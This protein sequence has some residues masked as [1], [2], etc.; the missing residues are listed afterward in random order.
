MTDAA[1][2]LDL[3]A[4]QSLLERCQGNDETS[5]GNVDGCSWSANK[6]SCGVACEKLSAASCQDPK[7]GCN[8]SDTAKCH[9]PGSL[10]DNE[11]SGK[12]SSPSSYSAQ[13]CAQANGNFEVSRDGSCQMKCEAIPDATTCA[14]QAD[15]DGTPR[16]VYANGK[17][18]N[19]VIAQC[20]PLLE[21]GPDIS[22]PV[23]QYR[24]GS[25][26]GEKFVIALICI[27][28]ILLLVTTEPVRGWLIAIGTAGV[29][30]IGAIRA[31][32]TSDLGATS[33]QDTA[34]AA[35][36]NPGADNPGAGSPDTDP[37]PAAATA[38]ADNPGTDSDTE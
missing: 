15:G 38:A 20:Q 22:M 35:A 32:R 30:R 12:G 26:P 14:A 31:R 28:F 10:G 24:L 6:N 1:T 4:A 13:D 3:Q 5:C 19:K 11:A 37:D 33:S 21:E 2:F 23:G 27:A 7:Y 17:C 34:A 16:C 18:M 9:T 8:W 36:D 29:T 25:T